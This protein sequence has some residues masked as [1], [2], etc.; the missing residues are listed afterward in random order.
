MLV[1]YVFK[2]IT[3]YRFCSVFLS[4]QGWEQEIFPQFYNKLV[5]SKYTC[6]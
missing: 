4:E 2:S 6:T 3:H 1:I 5:A